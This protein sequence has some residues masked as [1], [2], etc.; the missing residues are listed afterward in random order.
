MVGTEILAIVS[1]GMVSLGL[2]E[3]WLHRRRLRKIPNRVHVA[4]TRGKSS[5]TRLIAAGMN[6]ANIPT[7]AKTTGTTARMIFPNGREVPVYRPAGAN[8][9]EQKRIVSA[10]AGVKAEGL[11]MECMAL[12]PMLHYVA[13]RY[14]VRATHGVISNV[15]ADHL[16]VMGPGEDDV[17][18]ALAGMIPPKGVLYTAEQ[19][20]LHILADVAKDRQT[21]LVSIDE[22]D[23]ESVSDD[24]MAGFSYAEHK[25]NVALA[26][27]ILADFNIDRQTALQGMWKVKPDPGALSEHILDYFGRRII[28]VNG[29]AAN[30]P[31]STERIWHW[32]V[33]K[34]SD[35]DKVVGVFNLRSD[36]PSRTQQLVR[37]VDFWKEADRIVLMGT[38]SYLFAKLATGLGVDLAHFFISEGTRTEDIFETILGACG[39]T[40]LV[41]GMGNIGGHGLD[42]VRYFRNRAIP[43]N[44]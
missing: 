13:E 20:H 5:V 8:I 16:D 29:F 38:G 2:F 6:G 11:V 19:R 12:Q 41:V 37:D 42:L 1:A 4:G 36:R 21:R 26:L 17:A 24:D 14:F 35:V 27:R 3:N 40:T 15:R 39:K 30:D 28:F 43:E 10:A 31:E 23:I 18:R 25:E 32:A 7:V 9:I 34:Y 44:S 33:E 22:H